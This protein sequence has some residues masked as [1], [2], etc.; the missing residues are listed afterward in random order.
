M[1]VSSTLMLPR[2]RAEFD[3]ACCPDR[4]GDPSLGHSASRSHLWRHLGFPDQGES[5]RSI[6]SVCERAPP[7]AI[8]HYR[9]PV[10]A[11]ELDADTT[12]PSDFALLRNGG[13]A[14]YR[15]RA[16]L[17]EA[18]QELRQLGYEGIRLD[19]HGWTESE[20][21]E[22]FASALNFPDYYGRN[23]NAL[24]DCLY[25]VP[26][27]DYGWSATSA[28]LAVTVD[29]YGAFAEGEPDLATSVADLL[30]GATSTAL[31]FG[32]RPGGV[33]ERPDRLGRRVGA[34]DRVL[35]VRGAEPRP[36]G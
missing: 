32:H 22:A 8:R 31:L 15:G 33:V 17:D 16:V 14:T 12:H 28:G 5:K 6:V 10:V 23:L 30:A 13:L 25:D 18:E 36:S 19:A 11:F 27:G 1:R 24:A 21:H 34:A 2:R 7:V 35:D 4:A 20:L 26:H 9:R 29:G 3:Q